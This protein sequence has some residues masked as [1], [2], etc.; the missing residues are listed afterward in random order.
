MSKGFPML[1][2]A[3]RAI[4]RLRT[5][6]HEA[7][8][9]G[10]CVRDVL[11]GRTPTDYDLTTSALPEETEAVFAGERLI[12]TGLQHGTVTVLLEGVPLEITTYRVDGGYT[13]ARHPDGVTFTRSLREDA[14]RRD[15]TINA[16][17]Y[18]PGEG[19]QDFF[20]GQADL[21]AGV[22]RAVGEA[23][24]RFQEDAL[25]IL[26]AIRFASVLGFE[27]DP[28]TDAAARRNAPLLQ[29]ISV[30]RVFVEL[31]KLLCGP[32]AGKILRA[33]P[34]ILGVVLPELTPTVGFA[35]HNIH[36]CYDVY[37][38]TAVAVDHVPPEV[39]LRLAA[40]FHD[41]GKPATFSMGED[42]QGHFYGHPKVSAALAE[43]I[44]LRLRAPKRLREEVVRLVE[45]HD[46]PLS[47]EPRLIRRRLQQLGEEGFFALLALQ[48]GDAAACSLSD[49]TREDGRNAVET[50]ARAIL[51]ARPCLSVGD[52]AVNGRDV[53]ALGYCGPGVGAAL[54]RLLERVIAEEIPNEKTA[55]LQSLEEKD[56]KK[57]E[58][59]GKK[60]S[61]K[62]Y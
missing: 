5:A 51:A 55:L 47:S 61:F 15:F 50:A 44:L 3:A 27:L 19:L 7:W 14:A 20:G 37:T 56:A 52:L 22:I 13:D 46:W 49:C 29:K 57:P 30:E 2:Q 41:L 21:S 28:E 26:R 53:M 58:K 18:A 40:L 11:L 39:T 16:M 12:E 45:V 32:G 4:E 1:P 8:I 60:V 62:T 36:H 43:Q 17:A 9:V 23:D 24:R 42:G 34:D 38:H 59:K 10:G 48:K 54:R 6:G 33:Y 25:R 31:S 35:Q